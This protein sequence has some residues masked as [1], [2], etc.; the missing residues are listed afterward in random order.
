MRAQLTLMMAITTGATVANLYYNQPLLALL[1]NDFHT[2]AHQVSFIPTLTQMG[3]A[4]GILLLAPLGDLVE[5]RRLIVMMM[6]L[7]AVALAGAAV[8]PGLPWLVGSS[9]AIGTT[10]IAAQVILPFAAQLAKPQQRGKVVGTVMSGLLIGILLARTVS[11]YV[12]RIWSWRCM[13]WIASG[14][15]VVLAIAMAKVL[16]RSQPSLRMSYPG[17]M[18]SLIQLAQTQPRLQRASI[19]GAMSFAAF[20]AFWT[21]LTF[22]L[23]QPPY[24]YGSDVA[25]LFGLVGVVGAT[26][27]PIVGNL[28]DRRSSQLT[29]ALGIAINTVAFLVMWVLG[30]HLWG[31]I[32]GVILLDFGLQATQISNQ[33]T[34]YSLPTEM[35]SRLNA[36]YITFYFMGGALGSFLG[37]FGWSHGRWSGVCLSS[38][39]LL[40]IAAVAYL[41]WGG[42]QASDGV[43]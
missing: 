22:L 20:S 40:A 15:T 26:A 1:A 27:A 28:A 29:V 31:L 10:A 23:E 37:A 11:G 17:L 33:A 4:L 5:R 36:L 18:R 38:L 6:M 41:R 2:V 12:G 39:G 24:Q 19:I 21:T 42:E 14:L 7:T 34:I 13:Y 43:S 3:H 9:F 16:P 35:H 32:V 8:A 25:G 30:S